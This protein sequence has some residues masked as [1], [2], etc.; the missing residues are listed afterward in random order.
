MR[1][2]A[3]NARSLLGFLAHLVGMSRLSALGIL[4]VAAALTEGVGLLLLV[5]LTQAVAAGGELTVQGI[6]LDALPLGGLLAGFAALVAARALLVYLLRERQRDLGLIATRRLRSLCQDAIARAEWRW[7]ARQSGAEHAAMVMGHS[8][9]IGA[10]AN[11]V[12]AFLSSAV[13]ALALVCAAALLSWKLTLLALALGLAVALPGGWLRLRNGGGSPSHAQAYAALQGRVSEGIDHL[14]AAR[15][16]GAGAAIAAEFERS[17]DRLMEVEQAYHRKLSQAQFAFQAGAGVML[18]LIVWIGLEIFATPLPI[19]IPV[20]AI[21]ARL[22]PAVGAMQIGWRS[23]KFCE[24]ALQD[25]LAMVRSA[26]QAAE[27][28][29]TG[30]PPPRLAHTLEVRNLTVRFEGRDQTV[31]RD[32]DG[33]IEAGSI[34]AVTGVSGSGKSTLADVLSGLLAPD[35]GH[36]LIDGQKLDGETR[37]AWR[38]R[39]AYVEQDPYLFDD[40]IAANLAWGRPGIAR[41]RLITALQAA[42]AAFAMALPDGLDTRVGETGRQLS[43]GE[44]QRLALARALLQDPDLLIL[45]EVTSALD[46]ASEAAI[47]ESISALRG[48]CTILVL[49]HRPALLALADAAIE[50]PFHAR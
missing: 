1:A 32:L 46:A 7:L 33:I 31:L 4:M 44:R 2:E 43:G 28:D 17:A 11:Q 24:P 22:L 8:E 35:A 26:R 6:R 18:A 5:P 30:S 20:L 10:L 9:R 13:T 19:L 21:F 39:V 41:E 38:G 29:C 12:L 34:V 16:A 49:G 47:C 15:I 48:A 42:S 25:L 27:P 40:T 45:D 3:I 50:L 36:V 14:R 23:W 37:I